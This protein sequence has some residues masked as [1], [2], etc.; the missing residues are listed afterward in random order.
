MA[1][2]NGRRGLPG[3][4]ET[5]QGYYDAMVKLGREVMHA[6]ALALELPEDHFDRWLTGPMATLGPLHYPPQ[7]GQ[8]T[9]ARI[10][11]GAH[12]DFGCLTMLAQDSVGGLQ[13]RNSAGAM[14][15]RALYAGEFRAQHRRHAGALDQRRVQLDAPSR[16]Q[17]LGQGP[18][19]AAL[20][21]RSG[22]R[23][24]SDG[25]LHLHRSRAGRRNTRPPP[26]GNTCS[27]GSTRPSTTIAR[28]IR[29]TEGGR[30][31]LGAGTSCPKIHST[32][33][34]WD[35]PL[36]K[37]KIAAPGTPPPLRSRIQSRHLVQSHPSHLSDP[38]KHLSNF[39]F[40]WTTLHPKRTP[41]STSV[42]YNTF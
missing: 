7:K 41:T 17:Q 18:L 20:L 14:D 39:N 21:L 23:R 13:V 33:D 26:A 10:G 15:R 30:G 16:H 31:R 8:I 40:L 34:K 24:R 42:I 3:W 4:H 37:L 6:F 27:T 36:R 29:R 2:I 38:V 19:F 22:L 25:A 5:M 12:T 9:A 32:L 11:A 28:R 1:P 35:A